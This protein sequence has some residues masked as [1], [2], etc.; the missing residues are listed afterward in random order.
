MQDFASTG[1]LP[2]RGEAMRKLAI[3]GTAFFAVCILAF[4]LG[5]VN[6]GL[7][8][9]EA[10]DE[11]G[12]LLGF[13]IQVQGVSGFFSEVSGLGSETE[14]FEQKVVKQGVQHILK[15]PGRLKWGD[16]TLKRGITTNLAV[17]E[18][19]ELVEQ[20]DMKKARKSGQIIIFD[21]TLTPLARWQFKNAWPSKVTAR[22][23]D[24]ESNEFGIEELTLTHESLKRVD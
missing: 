24:A 13:A 16:I 5:Q 7:N 14:V 11:P 22:S 8:R 23:L 1:W 17:W 18:W 9:A 15:I 4:L 2:K 21:S 6:L 19:R 20:G 3:A 10:E 12:D